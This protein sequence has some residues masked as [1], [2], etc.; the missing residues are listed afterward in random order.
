[1][2]KIV[3]LLINLAALARDPA[4]GDLYVEEIFTGRIIRVQAP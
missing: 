3:L 2:R 1:M 4:N